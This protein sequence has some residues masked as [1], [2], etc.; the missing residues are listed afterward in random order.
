MNEQKH[1]INRQVLE[2]T[3]PERGVAQSVQNKTSEIIK[4]KLQPALDK[5]FSKLTTA[6][7]IVRIDKL[8][9]DLGTVSINELEKVLVERSLNEISDKINRLKISGLTV[10]ELKPE[11]GTSADKNGKFTSISK[12][13]DS[14][15]QFVY[16]L[17][18]GR[19]PWWHKSDK[20]SAKPVTDQ[21]EEIFAEILKI[22]VAFLK[23]SI[24]PLLGDPS[25]RKRLVFQF[26]H[27]QL[28]TLLKKL[29]KKLFETFFSV[30]KVLLSSVKSTEKRNDLTNCFYKIVLQNFTAEQNLKISD[31]KIE[32]IKELLGVFLTKYSIKENET[33]L[34]EILQTLENQQIKGSPENWDL[35]VATVVQVALKLHSQNQVLHEIIQDILS[36]SGLK[37]K[38]LVEQQLKISIKEYVKNNGA[39]KTESEINVKD[40]LVENIKGA[41]NENREKPFSPFPPKPADDAE[42]IVVSNAGLVLIHPFLRYF[43][44]GLGLLDKE[45]HFKSQSDVFKAIHLLQF[46]TTSQNSSPENDLPLNKILCGIEINEPVPKILQL[47]KMEKEECINLIITVL[48]RWDALKTTNPAA[49][50]DTYLQREGILKQSGQS[51][52]LTIERNSFDVMLE[53]LPWSI[54]FIKLPWLSQ[55]LYV[56]W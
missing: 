55:I 20:S 50:R 38:N 10:K 15:E 53:K 30:F 40:L 37:V 32:F 42:G 2:L 4:Y 45:L 14:L 8:V 3:I 52:N 23:G 12:S 6:D 51:W 29:D 35:T 11:S 22:E 54:N 27:S 48:E 56:E 33:L 41:I 28:N 25:V 34:I 36:K 21:L 47:S 24:F 1:I 43:F 13:K 17:Q 16:F 18:F 49:L 31:L 19:F 39:D 5:L 26:N 7:E 9:I 44:D 46:I